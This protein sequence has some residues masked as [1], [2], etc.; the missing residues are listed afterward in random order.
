MTEAPQEWAPVWKPCH[1]EAVMSESMS[2]D[3][4][5]ATASTQKFTLTF[6]LLPAA[7]WWEGGLGA[8]Q[9]EEPAPAPQVSAGEH[10]A[11]RAEHLAFRAH[12]GGAALCS[13][14]DSEGYLRGRLGSRD[15][16]R[17]PR[18]TWGGAQQRAFLGG[19]GTGW[20]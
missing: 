11:W 17:R 4:P 12:A 2:P 9:E 7:Q 13:R 5:P 18:R 15:L 10:P 20:L 14:A 6:L 16:W 19:Q 8:S 3:V 1:H